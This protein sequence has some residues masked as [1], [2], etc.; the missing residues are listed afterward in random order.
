MKHLLLYSLMFRRINDYQN[1]HIQICG[2]KFNTIQR[3]LVN[4]SLR[5]EETRIKHP[6][7]TTEMMNESEDSK[8]RYLK[9]V[10]VER[11]RELMERV[12]QK[13][14]P[15][16]QLNKL[17]HSCIDKTRLVWSQSIH[18]ILSHKTY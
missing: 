9:H 2:I 12:L 8:S 13:K 18:N 7:E 6:D 5:A 3:A 10:F 16:F 4:K 11:D 14:S 1:T 15:T 17:G